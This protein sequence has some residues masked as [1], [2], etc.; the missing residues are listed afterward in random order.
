MK[1]MQRL[2][3]AVCLVMLP[4]LSWAALLG[5]D[6]EGKQQ[7]LSGYKGKWVVVN[8]WA[9]W[10]P[11]CIKELPE[12]DQFH[13]KFKDKHAVVVGINMENIS[14]ERLKA[15][16]AERKLSF[17][18]ISTKPAKSSVFGT[19][20]GMP[21]TYLVSPEGELVAKQEGGITAEDLEGFINKHNP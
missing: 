14:L 5:V 4:A 7:D 8:Y 20:T 11:P 19:L 17:P 1:R 2:G 12:L 15:F 10:C 3:V 21:T 6:L 13:N 18:V 16:I 9:T